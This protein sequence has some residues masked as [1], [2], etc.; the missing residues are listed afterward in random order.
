MAQ[1]R[2]VQA[3]EVV[4][5]SA[6]IESTESTSV[7]P[8][9]TTEG[10]DQTLEVKD[11][12]AWEPVLNLVPESIQGAMKPHFV[13]WDEN[14]R[15]L[16]TEYNEYKTKNG[17]REPSPLDEFQGVDPNNIRTALGIM[18]SIGTNPRQVAELMAEQL[19]LSLSEAKAAV[20]EAQ[21]QVPVTMEFNED[22][23]PRLKQMYD[24][25]EAQRQQIEQFTA[26]QQS[27]FQQEQQRQLDAQRSAEEAKVNQQVE[28]ELQQLFQNVPGL[29]Q[30]QAM[31]NLIFPL[32]GV[33]AQ[34]GSQSPLQDAYTQV[35]GLMQSHR[36]TEVQK[37]TPLFV[38]TGGQAPPVSDT[39]NKSTRERALEMIQ[40]LHSN[41]QG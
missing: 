23:D 5:M 13:K 29:E 25:M 26:Q 28:V 3:W 41:G 38:P 27:Y 35:N 4:V 16:E 21:Q 6:P 40:A 11:N 22:D 7:S 15:K 1:G 10:G 19:G 18:Q 2:K 33:L 8:V 34:Q 12:P 14:Y 37:S 39:A 17:P 9:T 30:N 24:A 36:S 32:A 20:K 31:M